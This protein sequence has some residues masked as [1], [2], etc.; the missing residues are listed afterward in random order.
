[1]TRRKTRP[2]T[3]GTRGRSSAPVLVA[4]GLPDSFDDHLLYVFVI[5]PGVGESVLVRAPE[6]RWLVVDGC[7]IGGHVSAPLTL[8][9]RYR[10]KQIEAAILTHPHTDH[11]RGI[12]ALLRDDEISCIRVG[13]VDGWQATPTLFELEAAQRRREAGHAADPERQQKARAVEHA[14]A[15]IRSRWDGD[16]ASRWALKLGA[17]ALPLGSSAVAHVVTPTDTEI[18]TARLVLS[19]GRFDMNRLSAV[20]LVC[21]GTARILLGA[22]LPHRSGGRVLTGCGW[23]QAL[24]DEPRVRQATIL[25]APHHGSTNALAPDLLTALAVGQRTL[26][27]T[28][29]SS[30]GLP[31]PH[32]GEGLALMLRDHAAVRVTA[33]DESLPGAGR[34]EPVVTR[35]QLLRA[36]KASV[37]PGM[38]SLRWVPNPR[39]TGVEQVCVTTSVGMDGG[40]RTVWMGGLTATIV[41]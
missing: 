12:P 20:L 11:A 10:V 13:C 4:S 27:V 41:E 19:S 17:P 39:A 32:D 40:V 26:V 14:M 28:P 35:G 30:K 22:D 1:M 38:P 7:S 29:F 21:F 36:M 23:T 24:A 5:G 15:V 8:L 16:P 37:R 9:R 33:L 6:G 34:R 3:S 25:K 2:A 18:V 31:L